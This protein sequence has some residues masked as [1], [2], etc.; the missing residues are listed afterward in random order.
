MTIG[1][2]RLGHRT[3]H[4]MPLLYFTLLIHKFLPITNMRLCARMP[5]ALG[6]SH[7]ASIRG[8]FFPLLNCRCRQ[9]AHAPVGTKKLRGI[10][11][12]A[13]YTVSQAQPITRSFL[14]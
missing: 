3:C 1:H 7:L 8:L 12:A 10:S 2:A 9:S 6:I 4:H 11:L 14:E 5:Q 13:Y